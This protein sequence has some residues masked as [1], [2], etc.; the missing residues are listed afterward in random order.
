VP[1]LKNPAVAPVAS[2]R[3]QIS[4]VL[5]GTEKGWAETA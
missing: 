4:P 3:Q 2:S 5:G 1:R